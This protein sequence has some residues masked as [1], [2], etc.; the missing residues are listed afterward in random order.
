MKIPSIHQ[1]PS[2]AGRYGK[3]HL[4]GHGHWTLC[5]F[6]IG[7]NWRRVLEPT[8]PLCARCVKIA[9]ASGYVVPAAP[10]APTRRNG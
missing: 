7:G 6:W 9:A 8:Q 1:A 3:A 10:E 4:S 2:S 5:G